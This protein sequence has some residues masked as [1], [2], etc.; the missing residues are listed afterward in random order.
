L[1]K[2]SLDGAALDITSDGSGYTVLLDDRPLRVELLEAD[3]T[4]LDLSLEGRRVVAYV[5]ID[6]P[7]HWVT[8][9]GRTIRL[10]RG[11][12]PARGS[13]G[14]D[15]SSDLSAPMPGQVR[16]VNVQAGDNVTKGQVL[17]V[18]EAMKMEIRIQAPFDASVTSVDA[19]V[20]QTVEREQLLVRLEKA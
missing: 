1:T 10:T 11:S 16:A 13:G 5:S 19:Q 15:G 8:V 14:H 20:G 9:A 18:L 12:A 4:R 7:V 6:G 17:V 3:G 2:V